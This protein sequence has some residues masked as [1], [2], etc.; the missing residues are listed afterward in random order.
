MKQLIS[1]SP[2]IEIYA[3]SQNAT[4][5]Y[6]VYQQIYVSMTTNLKYM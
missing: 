3:V 1:C 5:L 6:I 2:I 4:K